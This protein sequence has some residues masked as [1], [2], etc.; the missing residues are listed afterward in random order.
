MNSNSSFRK[1]VLLGA[2]TRQEAETSS[3]GGVCG[4]VLAVTPPSQMSDQGCPAHGA[5]AGPSD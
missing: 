2:L 3:R 5:L 4:D 1:E